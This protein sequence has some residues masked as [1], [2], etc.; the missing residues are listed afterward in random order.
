L[1]D[2]NNQEKQGRKFG[3]CFQKKLIVGNHFGLKV[4]QQDFIFWGS[5]R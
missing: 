2:E 4:F 1:E 3:L 5:E